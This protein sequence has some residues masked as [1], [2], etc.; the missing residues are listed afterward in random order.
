[1][2]SFEALMCYAYEAIEDNVRFIYAIKLAL[3]FIDLQRSF[4]YS[5]K[6]KCRNN[7]LLAN[8]TIDDR[9]GKNYTKFA[10]FGKRK[11]PKDVVLKKEPAG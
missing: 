11:A 8:I 7:A 3:R 2:I 5:D 4:R 1:M 6:T 10:A 9:L